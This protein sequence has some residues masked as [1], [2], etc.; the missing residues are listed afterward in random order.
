MLSEIRPRPLIPADVLDRLKSAVGPAGFLE[1]AAD[2]EPYRKSWR[3]PNEGKTPLVVRPQSTAEVSEVVKICAAHRVAIVPQGGNTGLTFAGQ[4]HDDMSEIVVSTER[5]K[6]IRTIDLANDTMT[7]ESGV[8]LQQIQ[9]AARAKSRL[10]PLSLGAQGSCRIGGN[11]STNAGGIQVIRYGNTRNLVLG[12]EV[13]L[14]DGRIWDG[15]RGLRK[16]NTG[17]DLKQLFIGGEGTLGII[18]AAV[19][20]LFPLPTARETAWIAVESPADGIALLGR[21]K[22]ALGDHVTA[23]ELIC[24]KIVD[25]LIESIPV[26][27]SPLEGSHPW[28]VLM[29]VSSQGAP[30]SLQE[31]LS[32]ALGAA[33]ESGLVK[34][35]IIASSEAQAAKLWRMREDMAIAQQKAGGTISHDVSVPVSKIPEFL[36]RAD[37]ALE[38]AY[39]GIRHCAFGHAGDGNIHYNPIRPLN[40]PY[41]RY[42]AE[43]PKVNAI[44]HDIVVSLGGSISAEHG[45][46]RMRLEENY[47]YKSQVELDMMHAIKRALD[48]DGIMNPGKMLRAEL[49]PAPAR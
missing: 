24:R 3:Y 34:D 32:E 47:R 33:M 19:L 4:P 7:V 9:D 46:G 14:P 2:T 22:E 37:A 36:A 49:G 11:I 16:D 42:M 21:M 26:H 41:E 44:V 17:Y 15:L 1:T 29:D 40:W 31:P 43:F 45:I 39:P 5:L 6:K 12:L 20:K 25:V 27:E 18:T 8:V 35:A 10:F 30:G 48:P 13:V 28:Y 38:Q 23:F